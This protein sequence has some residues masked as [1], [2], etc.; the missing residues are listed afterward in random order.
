MCG[1]RKMWLVIMG[2][3]SS[4][5]RREVPNQETSG[6]LSANARRFPRFVE[7]A[8]G[9]RRIPAEGAE[10]LAGGGVRA[11]SR[12][13]G[14]PPAELEKRSGLPS[15]VNGL[16]SDTIPARAVTRRS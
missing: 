14:P 6:N 10:W 9:A 16:S 15:R 11:V 3:N 7:I 4:L 5:S 2:I 1:S 13:R 8:G 12:D